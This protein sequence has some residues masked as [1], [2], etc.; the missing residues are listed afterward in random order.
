VLQDNTHA[1]ADAEARRD[2]LTRQIEELLPSWSMAP[3]SRRCGRCAGS[4]LVVA[5][6]VVAEVGEFR[7][8]ATPG[9]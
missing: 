8:F 3:R 7:R 4:P 6:T 9:S 1:V 2:R 5:V